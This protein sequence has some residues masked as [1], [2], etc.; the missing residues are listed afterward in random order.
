MWNPF[1]RKAPEAEHK[2]LATAGSWWE[3]I[4]GSAPTAAG[5]TV[6]ATAA[7]KVPVVANAIQ[8]ISEAVASLDVF[9]KRI[10]DGA[11]VD[12]E[13][14]QLLPLLRDEVNG[15][16]SSFEFFRQIVVD[17]LT[18]DQGGMA[19]VIR[20]DDGRPLEIVRYML[21]ILVLDVDQTTGERTY[22]LNAQTVPVQNVIHLLRPLG[23]AP[24]TLAREAIGV[25]LFGLAD[26]GYPELGSFSLQELS[27]L[28]LPFGMGIERDLFFTGDVPIS[29]WAEAARQAGSIRAAEQVI[30]RMRMLS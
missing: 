28:R 29:V 24:L 4:A 14:H 9:V 21:G 3:L 13:G 2:S 16:T 18:L 19:M 5:I 17:A 22:K 20:A 7:L 10:E 1:A 12:E 23:I 6:T 11:E 25:V 27:S 26:L 15:R 8:R 30:R